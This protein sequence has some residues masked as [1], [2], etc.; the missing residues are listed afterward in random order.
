MSDDRA[1]SGQEVD[2]S[3][4]SEIGQAAVHYVKDLHWSVIPLRAKGKEPATK[5]GLN[6]WTDDPAMV[7]KYYR[8]HPKAN[9]GIVTGQ[10]SHGLFVLDFDVDEDTGKN[11]YKTLND[12]EK[13]YGELPATTTAITGGGGMHY[14]YRTDRT[15]IRPTTNGTLG[16]DVRCEGAYIVA[17]PSVHPSGRR[18]EWQDAPED[19][20]PTL[21]DS[22][23]YD[24]LD[25]I[26]RNGGEDEETK[27]SNGKFQL[28]DE[29][30]KG[31]RDK[32]L[33]R[34]AAHLRAI[35]RSDDEMMAAVMGANVM[36]CNPPMDSKEIER[37][38][39]SAC[40]YERG[41]SE[42]TKDDGVAVG[43]PGGASP[44]IGGNDDGN[45]NPSAPT[46]I[47]PRGSVQTRA[48][49]DYIISARHACLVDG[50]PA[51][52]TGRRWE[53]GDWA[54]KR[55]AL[56]LCPKCK[57]GDKREVFSYVLDKA[58][59]VSSSNSFDGRYYVQ[60][61]DR[62]IDAIT[63]QEVEPSPEMY[64]I[65]T[66][67]FEYR[68]FRRLEDGT[69][70]H[71]ETA[72]RFMWSISANDRQVFQ[73]LCEIIGAEICS[74]RIVSQAPML[75]G[76]A[77]GGAGKASNG[78]STFINWMR[79]I[80]GSENV[81]SLTLDEFETRFNRKYIAGKLA[82]LGDDIPDGFLNG[83]SLSTFK[84]MVTGDEIYADVKGTDGFQFRPSA[85]QVFSMNT[86]PKMSDTTDGVMRRLDFV[87]FRAE[88]RPGDDG[89]DPHMEQKL[90]RKEALQYGAW[91]GL[92]ALPG[93]IERG[94]FCEISGM[95]D[96]LMAVRID[97]S[98]VARWITEDLVD[99]CEDIDN[100]TVAEVYQKY[101]DWTQSA[102]EKY[103]KSRAEF[104]KD[105][106]S[107]FDAMS[108][109]STPE[110]VNSIS[111]ECVRLR[112]R[113]KVSRGYKVIKNATSEQEDPFT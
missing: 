82:N 94:K 95:Q 63:M 102:G 90:A 97:N 2:I 16:V 22:R 100:H 67:P 59:H 58:P 81:S 38:V 15:N 92:K 91:L 76:R 99:P 113:N 55:Q 66:L 69:Y 89:Y 106:V 87:P 17:P 103:P 54:I 108:V 79:A 8:L 19:I 1:E 36:R 6:D 60:F 52:W 65:G 47:G 50:A 4:L 13:V 34:Y 78:K 71:D 5:N 84:K 29:I 86:I 9:L 73:H 26:T 53:F 68:E 44:S 10:P 23:V 107:Y 57:I 28:P 56:M 62:T 21:A 70:E 20:E 61:N 40:R 33:F 14:I 88:F 32:T 48:L 77:R 51:V 11:G 104:S 93:L 43:K 75:V 74:A 12:W 39:K 3:E 96:E 18:Y 109:N 80:A 27:K 37:I 111:I 49:G 31:S 24:F 25:Y 105:L 35:G 46:F 72:Y 83:N 30:K 85:L 101:K 42:D 64:I 112:R 41:E 110:S 45:E 98:S 7:A